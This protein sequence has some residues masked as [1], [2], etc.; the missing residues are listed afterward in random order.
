[1][2]RKPLVAVRLVAGGAEG[3]GT[4]FG[5]REALHDTADADCYLVLA[6]QGIVHGPVRP[7]HRGTCRRGAM[8]DTIIVDLDEDAPPGLRR[9][10]R[11]VV[12]LDGQIELVPEV[13]FVTK[14]FRGQNDRGLL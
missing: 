2:T 9:L 14:S 4:D 1:M 6:F 10:T 13:G 8:A 5:S 12:D 7:G 3:D 11:R